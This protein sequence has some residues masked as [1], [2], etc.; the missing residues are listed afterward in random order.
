MYVPAHFAE[1]RLDVLHATIARTGLATLV[2]LGAD[3]LIATH[4]PMLLDAHDG[5]FGTLYGHVARG[6]PH[7]RAA[8]GEVDSLAMFLGP[9]AYISPTWYATKRETGKAVP[10]WNYLTVHAYGRLETFDDPDQLRA[11]VERLTRHHEADRDPAWHVA[12]APTEF[13]AGQLRG[14][15]GLRLVLTRLEGKWKLGQNRPDADR[16]GA[17]AGLDASDDPADHAV[18]ELMRSKLG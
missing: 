17:I 11:H 2:S 6:N 8:G 1:N 7:A 3:G 13:V 4:L 9:N 10:T 16:T 15:V 5:E 18:A 12:D 14:I